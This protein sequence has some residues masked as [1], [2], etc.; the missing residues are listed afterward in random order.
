MS[1]ALTVEQAGDII[2]DALIACGFKHRKGD[3]WLRGPCLVA[4]R[5][6]IERQRGM[7]SSR[8]EL[9]IKAA[10]LSQPRNPIMERDRELEELRIRC[11]NAAQSHTASSEERL[12]VAQ[13]F[14]DFVMGQAPKT[15]R[16]TITAALDA[17]GL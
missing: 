15:P 4:A 6:L 10:E 11:L 1:A 13:K 5:S 7:I 16:E 3:P 2:E 12:A 9:Q 8:L 14:F 17:A